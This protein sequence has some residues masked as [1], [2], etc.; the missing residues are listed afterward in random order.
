MGKQIGQTE[1]SRAKPQKIWLYGNHAVK[2]AIYNPDREVLKIV[3]TQTARGRLGEMLTYAKDHLGIETQTIGPNQIDSLFAKGAVH[4][5]IG[6]F[7]KPLKNVDLV[8]SCSLNSNT[9]QTV[10][11]LDQVT[12]PQNFGAIIRSAAAFG[13]KAIVVQER[14]TPRET[15]LLAKIASGALDRIPIVRTVNLS[16]ALT[17]LAELGYWRIGLDPNSNE[18]LDSAKVNQTIALVLGAEGSGLRP[19]TSKQCDLI[20]RLNVPGTQADLNVAVAS[21]IALYEI[22]RGHGITSKVGSEE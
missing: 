5:G 21:S 17:K 13:A 3:V 14:H 11:L 1:F 22:V 12:D 2:A 16:R 10:V 6:L 4:Q 8:E 19:S 15:G 7:T 20:T 18:I 9:H